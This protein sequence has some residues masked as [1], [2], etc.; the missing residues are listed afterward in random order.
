MQARTL[1]AAQQAMRQREE[2]HR[3]DRKRQVAIQ[4]RE[5]ARQRACEVQREEELLTSGRELTTDELFELAGDPKDWQRI[6]EKDFDAMKLKPGDLEQFS[7][8]SD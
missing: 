4:W 6:T 7:L 2:Q 1:T 3:A 5:A 8:G